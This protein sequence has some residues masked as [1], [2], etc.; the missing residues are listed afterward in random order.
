MAPPGLDPE[1]ARVLRS[2]FMA[3]TRDPG[4]RS[5]VQKTGVELEPLPGE[6]L[7]E[8]V[9]RGLDIPAQTRERAKSVF[10]R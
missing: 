8:V 7:A 4:F 3:M 9:A 5:D 1:A 6:A 10:G 2:G